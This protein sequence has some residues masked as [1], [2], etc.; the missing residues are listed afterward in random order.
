MNKA[1]KLEY[2]QSD[3]QSDFRT[4]ADIVPARD[5]KSYSRANRSSASKP[6]R[7]V[8]CEESYKI[9]RDVNKY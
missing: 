7:I 6:D 5:V 2:P 3:Y 8:T 4:A 9:R 1:K